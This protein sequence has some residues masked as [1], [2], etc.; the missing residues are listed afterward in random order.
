VRVFPNYG[1]HASLRQAWTYFEYITLPRCVPSTTVHGDYTKAPP[2]TL[3]SKLFPAWTTP[4]RELNDFGRRVLYVFSLCM[5]EWWRVIFFHLQVSVFFVA[6]CRCLLW[7]A[8]SPRGG[9]LAYWI[10]LPSIHA[11]LVVVSLWCCW[12]CQHYKSCTADIPHVFHHNMSTLSQLYLWR[13]N[14][15]AIQVDLLLWR[16]SRFYSKMTVLHCNGTKESSTFVSWYLL[17]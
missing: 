11:I 2:G 4:Q 1:K 16:I 12:S 3:G 14:W 9:L 7:D 15:M 8:E 5:D 17:L 13:S 10:A 6:G